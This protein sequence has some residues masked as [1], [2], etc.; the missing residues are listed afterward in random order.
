MVNIN[1]E[2]KK[3]DLFLVTAISIFLIGTGLII[4][5]NP[6]G[7]GGNPAVMGHS[8]D[9]VELPNCADGEVLKYL[10]GTWSCANDNGGDTGATANPK[11]ITIVGGGMVTR[12]FLLGA[13]RGLLCLGWG[14]VTCTSNIFAGYQS[15]DL[16]CNTGTRL[17]LYSSGSSNYYACYTSSTS[18]TITIHSGSDVVESYSCDNEFGSPTC[19]PNTYI[20][21]D[22]GSRVD[23]SYSDY[24]YC[25]IAD[26]IFG[27]GV[28]CK[29]RNDGP[30]IKYYC[31][32]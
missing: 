31:Y 2:V 24:D 16:V 29:N 14:D 3:K 32:A 30:V 6:S 12:G 5:F 4:A 9:E 28:Y 19:V 26:L 23:F 27:S 17:Y 15:A 7:S 13:N 1:L 22:Y 10:S 25:D 20:I 21:C 18:D 8:L 11:G